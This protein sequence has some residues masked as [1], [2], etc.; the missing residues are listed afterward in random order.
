MTTHTPKTSR[1]LI[2]GHV[3]GVAFRY[4]T[5]QEAAARGLVGWVRNLYDG[6]VEAVFQGP[7]D[8]VEAMIAACYQG[9]RLARVEAVAVEEIAPIEAGGF[10]VLPSA[11]GP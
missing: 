2:S 4:W 11:P 8:A 6:R 5:E 10:A 7:E 3:Q 9:P 1:V